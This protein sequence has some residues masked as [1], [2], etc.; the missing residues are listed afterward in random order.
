M[1]TPARTF[2]PSEIGEL[3]RADRKGNAKGRCPF[4][5]SK[6]GKSF[7]VNLQSGKFFCFGCGGSGDM[8][9]FVRKRY[10]FTFKEA[11]QRLNAWDEAPSP[12]TVR[13]LA[14]EKSQRDRE[15][16]KAAAA[17]EAERCKRL[18]LRDQIHAAH[19]NWQRACARLTE[20]KRGSPP[21]FDGEVES[22]WSVL[23]LAFRDLHETESAY[24]KASGLD[25][26]E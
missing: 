8:I 16:E 4:H 23:S 20:I 5:N 25:S 2:W 24:C 15:R 7:S 11:C 22:C 12:A 21:V 3:T 17:K 26:P 18:E 9:G 19:R 1:M 14:A 6:S 10:G 13:K